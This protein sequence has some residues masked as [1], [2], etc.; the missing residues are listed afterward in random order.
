MKR[1]DVFINSKPEAAH[2]VYFLCLS[3]FDVIYLSN[4]SA[5]GV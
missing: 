5:T 2:Y 4:K 3:L 1:V